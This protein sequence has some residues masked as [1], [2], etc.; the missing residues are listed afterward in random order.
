MPTALPLT[1]GRIVEEAIAL[2]DDE[3][4]ESL[5]MRRLAARLG[6]STMSTYHHV[7]DKA[8]LVEAVAEA[9]MTNLEQPAEDVP[10]EDAVRR[11][12]RSFRSLTLEHPAAFRVML[13]G[14]R[15]AALTRTAA[16]VVSRLEASGFA[17]ADA[18]IAFRVLMR[19]LLGS[20][21]VES[22]SHMAP[23][24]LQRTFDFGLESMIAG[25]AASPRAPRPSKPSGA[26]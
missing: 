12:S 10:W 26:R 15:P 9:V 3:G 22:D 17:A 25:I 13:A 16:R 7:P 8:A 4:A 11:M 23:A 24:A 1:R 2:L 20:T 14:E 5:S 6:T 18:L 21:M 19:Y